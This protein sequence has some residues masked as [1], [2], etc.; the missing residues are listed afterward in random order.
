MRKIN[1]IILTLIII[2]TLSFLFRVGRIDYPKNYIFDEVY[3]AFTAQEYLK[4]NSQAWEWFSN[5][6]AGKAYN[7]VNPPLAQEIMTASMYIFRSQEAWTWRIPGVFLGTLAIYLVFKITQ[8][9]FKKDSL[10]L[11]SAFIFS[12]DGLNF[13]QS[14]VAM[15]DVYLVTF[16][17]L[18]FYL[19]LKSR[20]LFSSIFLGLA[21][22]I[23][24]TAIYL[25]IFLII[26]L[27]KQRKIYSISLFT[28]IPIV[29]YLFV[30]LPFFLTGHSFNQFIGLLQ[31]E[32]W[33]HINLKATHDFASPWWSWPLNLYPIWYFVDY[34]DNQIANIFASGNPLVFWGGAIAV[35]VSFF[36]AIKKKSTKL[37]LIIFGFLVFWIPWS[38]S[39]R[40]MFLY[41]F[42]PAVPFLSIALGYQLDKLLGK[43]NRLLFAILGLIL[44][45]FLLLYPFLTGVFLPKEWI[46]FFFLTNFA[47]NPFL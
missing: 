27:V 9:L 7:W 12:V 33:Y 21:F 35:A 41:Y 16:I 32:F 4:G 1:K 47:K 31:Q 30:Y 14:R 38:A 23:K 17:L 20:Y 8:L 43:N 37:G 34:R 19:F 42:A 22:S 36:E 40:I 39:T 24:W 6:P 13:V 45:A 28:I 29:V 3:Y 11:I 2:L 26:L 25:L 44:L 10:A 15:L 18:S 46:K 5:P